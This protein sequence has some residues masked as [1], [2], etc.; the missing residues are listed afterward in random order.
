[1]SVTGV[2]IAAPMVQ[3]AGFKVLTTHQP[4]AKGNER[5]NWVGEISIAPWVIYVLAQL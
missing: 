3:Q 5:F 1:V 2:D 4:L